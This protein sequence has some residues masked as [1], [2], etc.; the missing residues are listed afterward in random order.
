MEYEIVVSTL[1]G[2]DNSTVGQ[3]GCPFFRDVWTFEEYDV[4][5]VGSKRVEHAVEG[6]RVGPFVGVVT[7]DDTRCVAGV[8]AHEANVEASI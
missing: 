3:L 8:C 6:G 5:I 2:L 1:G 4:W 7:E